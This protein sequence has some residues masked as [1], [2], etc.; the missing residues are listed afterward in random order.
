M[1]STWEYYNSQFRLLREKGLVQWGQKYYDTSFEAKNRGKPALPPKH[2]SDVRQTVV[3]KGFCRAYQ[4]FGRCQFDKCSFSHKCYN[5]GFPYAER[6]CAAAG[7]PFVGSQALAAEC[8]KPEVMGQHTWPERIADSTIQLPTQKDPQSFQKDEATLS[9]SKT[10]SGVPTPIKTSKLAQ[11]INGYDTDLA[12]FLCQGFQRGFKVGFVGTPLSKHVH[13]LKSTDEHPQAV[14]D[15]IDKELKAGR[16][17][18]P[19]LQPP[20]PKYQMSPVG[21]VLKK[22]SGE[23]RII[24]NLSY[25]ESTSVNDKI[26]SSVC[27]VSYEDAIH[28]VKTSGVGS[29]TAKTDIK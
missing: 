19:F 10:K 20:F 5:C 1:G 9:V 3:P 15:Y 22:A 2:K 14:Q 18:G 12:M 11:W 29:Y 6:N 16:M 21:V 13:N 24:H 17:E 4:N 27:S 8:H 25:P 23:F 7:S 28:L 26:S